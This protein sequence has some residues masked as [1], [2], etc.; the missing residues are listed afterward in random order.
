MSGFFNDSGNSLGLI[1]DPYHSLCFLEFHPVLHEQLKVMA[2]VRAVRAVENRSVRYRIVR[3]VLEDE[4]SKRL[5]Q[6]LQTSEVR[7]KEV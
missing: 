6:W 1:D 4:T 7:L 2:E 5:N 3:T